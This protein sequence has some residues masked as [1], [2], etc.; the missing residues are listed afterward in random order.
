MP[1]WRCIY[2]T[3]VYRYGNDRSS[4]IVF[5]TFVYLT[6]DIVYGANDI[7]YWSML[8]SLTIDL[9]ER[10]KSGLSRKYAPMGMYIVVVAIIPVTEILSR[11][12]GSAV[13]GWFVF[14]LIVA[15]LLLLF[16]SFTVFGVKEMKG[17]FKEEEKT[18]LRKCFRSS[19]KT[20]N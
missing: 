8:P 7:A 1:F 3:D 15:G 20:T 19:L 13:Q 18:T 17:T 14:S 4:Y 12:T 16:Q 10:E 9:R 5:F 11:L 2:G 6:W